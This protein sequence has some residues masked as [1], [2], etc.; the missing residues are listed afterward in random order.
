MA[1][2][3]DHLR[4]QQEEAVYMLLKGSTRFIVPKQN[5]KLPPKYSKGFLCHM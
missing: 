3:T 5:S 1:L 2:K 4:R